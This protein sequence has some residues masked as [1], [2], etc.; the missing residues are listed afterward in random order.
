MVISVIRITSIVLLFLLLSCTGQD[1]TEPEEPA[2]PNILI[3]MSDNQSW[4]HVGAYGDSVVHTP[5]MDQVAKEGVLF[6]NAFCSAPSCSPARAA[7]ITGQDIWRLQQAANLWSS[8]PEEVV[9]PDLLAEAGYRVGIEGKGWG[10]GDATATGWTHNPGG[11]SYK[12]LDEFLDSTA[13]EEPWL[14]WFSSRHPHRPY[15]ENGWENAQVNLEDIEVPPYLPDVPA[16]REDIGDYYDEVQSFDR[17]VAEYL[18]LLKQ[19]GERKNTI[20]IVCSDNGWQMPRG[21]ANLYDFGTKI[22]FIVSWPGHFEENRKVTDFINLS[23]LAPTILDWAGL[24]TPEEMTANSFADILDSKKSG[25]ISNDRNQV[26][27]ARE[28]HAYVRSEGLGYPGRALRTKDYLYIRNYEPDRW[29]AGDPPLYGDV[30]A[31][32]LH[33]PAPTKIFLLNHHDDPK[34]RPLFE[35]AFGKRPYEELYDLTVDPYQMKNVAD[36]EAY[37][38]IKQRLSNQLSNYLVATG[39]PRETDAT[40]DWDGAVYYKERDKNPKP[41]EEARRKLGLKEV[42]HYD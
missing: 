11:P 42:Y 32:M 10:P 39:D 28:R 29:P 21:L 30:D 18:D 12:S 38:S 4:N 23:D 14:F 15:P 1:N 31:H 8:F 27:M 37:R 26:Y 9:F 19:R 7:M 5:A 17:Q 16:V 36:F 13:S 34:I 40:F 2:R 41:S 33:Y 25:Q 35:D 22:P 20:V 6:E 24:E 3:L